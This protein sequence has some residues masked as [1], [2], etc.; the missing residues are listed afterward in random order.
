MSINVEH[1][2]F[3]AIYDNAFSPE[4]CDKLIEYF[5]WCSKNNKTWG[6]PESSLDKKDNSCSLN[7]STTSEISY[8][9]QNL[10]GLIDEFNRVKNWKEDNEEEIKK[11]MES[12]RNQTYFKQI[13][14]DAI[15][16]IGAGGI[17]TVV[18]ALINF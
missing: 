16:I 14:R 7:P 18:N 5:E 15:V 6:R 8:T 1:D 13:V 12:T 11:T 17:F 4:Y 2:N 3:V 10:C 9:A